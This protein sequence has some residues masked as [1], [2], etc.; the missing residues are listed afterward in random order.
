MHR[1]H[2][3]NV[4]FIP[5]VKISQGWSKYQMNCLKPHTAVSLT[6]ESLIRANDGIN[7]CKLLV[8]LNNT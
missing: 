3:V 7:K 6:K 1:L 2:T 4:S 5:R 8:V